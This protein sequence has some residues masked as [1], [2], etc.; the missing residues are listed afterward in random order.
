[1]PSGGCGCQSCAEEGAIAFYGYLCSHRAM[2]RAASHPE[3]SQEPS[4]AAKHTGAA[5]LKEQ[6]PKYMSRP[7][8]VH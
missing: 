6:M 2:E 1:M 3:Q 4:K 8:G 5:P 7:H